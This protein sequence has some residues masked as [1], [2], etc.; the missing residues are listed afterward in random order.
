[1]A[2]TRLYFLCCWEC[3]YARLTATCRGGTSPTTLTMMCCGSSTRG[4]WWAT[5]SFWWEWPSIF[6]QRVFS[7]GS[8]S[9]EK[10]GTRY[11][12]VCA[13]DAACPSLLHPPFTPSSPSLLLQVACLS[14]YLVPTTLERWLSGWGTPWPAGPLWQFPLLSG[15]LYSWALE[16]CNTTGQFTE[17]SVSAWH[18]LGIPH[19]FSLACTLTF[20]AHRFYREKFED[21]PQHRKAF[22][23]FI[24]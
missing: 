2:A 1:M 16:P 18:A 9:Q 10:E 24:L 23:P 22:I 19:P 7:E 6:T 14:M 12:M 17:F 5:F 3:S 13:Q 8:E 21:Y 20:H 4:S 15:Q 11:L